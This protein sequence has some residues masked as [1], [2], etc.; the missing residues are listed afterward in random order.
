[1]LK[2][3]NLYGADTLQEQ[4]GDLKE[5]VVALG[6][7]EP[8]AVA[9]VAAKARE[10]LGEE[11]VSCVVRCRGDIVKNVKGISVPNS[12]NGRGIDT[13]AILEIVGGDASK[14]LPVLKFVTQAP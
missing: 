6:G 11:P 7:P 4:S 1:M 12:G 8:G 14:E 9:F 2:R 3:R 5:L 10:V 13:A